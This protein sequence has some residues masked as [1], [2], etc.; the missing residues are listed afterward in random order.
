MKNKVIF[1]LLFALGIF[2]EANSQ[3]VNVIYDHDSI[4]IKQIYESPFVSGEL[5]VVTGDPYSPFDNRFY[6]LPSPGAQLVEMT[7]T[8]VAAIKSDPVFQGSKMFFKGSIPGLGQ[9]LVMFDGTST[10]L[11][12]MDNSP[13][14]SSPIITEFD[15]DIFVNSIIGSSRELFKYDGGTGFSSI[16]DGSD[17]QPYEFAG[18][19][20]D[21]YAYITYSIQ[22]G[23]KI[24]VTTDNNGVL[25]TMEVAQLE[26]GEEFIDA[27][28]LNNEVFVQTKLNDAS[29]T[30]HRVYK[31]DDMNT[32]T[33]HFAD[34]GAF[35]SK[36]RMFEFGT[37]LMYYK[38]QSGHG[39]VLNITAQGQG[40]VHASIDVNQ[41]DMIE[42]HVVANNRLFLV[43][44]KYVVDA[45][46]GLVVDIVT[47]GMSIQPSSAYVGASSF[48]LYEI[49]PSLGQMSGIL[50]VGLNGIDYDRHMVSTDA[51]SLQVQDWPIEHKMVEMNGNILFLFREEGTPSIDIYELSPL[52]S[53]DDKE[54]SEVNLYPNPIESQGVLNIQTNTTSSAS[55]ENVS[56]KQFLEM[57]LQK[58]LNQVSLPQLSSGIYFL[59]IESGPYK[60]VVTP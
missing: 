55:I 44:E 1:T 56:G 51:G 46:S 57:D 59:K 60:I 31:I 6:V 29:G 28:V 47:D 23:T 12:D 27:K 18:Q 7:F 24:K 4:N 15:G 54:L 30:I 34:T 42:H 25:S 8:N 33:I 9:E 40:F 16:A 49:H 22:N 20:G 35:V 41:F 32:T 19:R 10:Y 45:T 53:I 2:S 26:T 13:A 5:I 38:V 36:G 17:D 3:S 11:F 50:E 39:E 52:L 14:S 43:G 37:S 21:D 48:F 58:G